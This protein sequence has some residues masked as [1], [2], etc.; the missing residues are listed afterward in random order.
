MNLSYS[1]L[2]VNRWVKLFVGYLASFAFLISMQS[3][4]PLMSAI[5]KVYNI[6][7]ATASMLMLAVALP[8]VF[9]SIIGG[10]II[11]KFGLKNMGLVGLFF[12]CIGGIICVF[13]TSYILL[14][15]GRAIIGLGGAITLVSTLALIAQIFKTEERGL[16]MGIFG[17]NMPIATI[18]SFNILGRFESTLN[19]RHI[20]WIPLVFSI[21]AFLVWA[22]FIHEGGNSSKKIKSKFSLSSLKNGRIWLIGLIWA[23][24]NMA[25]ISFTTWGPKLF[26]DYWSMPSTHSNFLSSLLMIGAL[27]APLTG[28]VSDRFGKRRTLIMISALGMAVSLFF[29][30]A[31]SGIILFL[32]IAFLG[33]IAAFI[34]PT[35]FAL[36][37]EIL[38]ESSIGFG[39]GILNTC[40]N[41]GVIV[42]PLFIGIIIDLT[43]NVT[44]TF[45][46][47]AIF[48]FLPFLLALLLRTN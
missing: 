41:I 39:Y 16:A 18:T 29:I 34:P 25:V 33:L 17:L 7:H 47:M 23:C 38:D 21:S 3:I 5:M 1:F 48:A 14:I 32:N 15:V 36:P 11:D 31:F 4:P 37:A 6:N 10:V 26:E 8:A 24:F 28:F 44:T 22:F 27:I 13:P 12:I 46:T 40:L 35:T 2:V 9:F 20:L 45:S 42:G 43:H 19:W 30:P